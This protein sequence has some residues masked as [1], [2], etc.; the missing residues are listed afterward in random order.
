MCIDQELLEIIC[1]PD[2]HQEL[3]LISVRQLGLLNDAQKIGDL[4]RREGNAVE[5]NLS[6]G[7]IREDGEVVYPIREG[8]PVLLSEEAIILSEDLKVEFFKDS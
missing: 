4:I 8:I 5:Y 2:T 7:L 1:C 3:S 6:G